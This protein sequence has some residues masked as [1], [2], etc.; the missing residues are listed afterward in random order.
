MAE[1]LPVRAS[2]P[3]RVCFGGESLDWMIQGPSV[4]GAIG[5]RTTVD[6]QPLTQLSDTVVI[7][8]G[9][10]FYQEKTLQ[11]SHV[12]KYDDQ[13]AKYVQAALKLFLD[14][15]SLD[16]SIA[17][18]THT[19]LPVKAG[20]SSS[21]AVSLAATA[22]LGRFL[23]IEQSQVEICHSAYL[24]ESKE[25]RTGAGQMDFYACGLGGVIYMNCH[26]E[27]PQ[28]LERYEHQDIHIVLVDTLSPH[29]TKTFIS[30]K[31][32]RFQE[33]EP[34]IK[35]YAQLAEAEVEHL[36]NLL[37]AFHE[38]AEE[39]G[40]LITQFHRYLSNYMRSST[41]LLDACVEVSIKNGAHGAKL[42]GTGMGGCMFAFVEEENVEK[43]TQALDKLPVE[44]F[45]TTIASEGVIFEN[46][47]K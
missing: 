40:T 1:R 12:G 17:I 46:N 7:Y 31:R 11:Q 22:A 3:G 15:N 41:F 42:T 44:T 33:G 2:A 28:P 34:L 24:V 37:P 45:H 32:K 19:E 16:E 29:S 20:V 9:E 43:L 4:V 30:S 26:S 38:N 10:P 35:K 27:P 5:L 8:S 6:V 23:A 21:A 39:I 18:R 13:D 14:Q 36:R 25:L 47:P